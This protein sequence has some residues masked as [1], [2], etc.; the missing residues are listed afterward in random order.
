MRSAHESPGSI[1]DLLERLAN[2]WVTLAVIPDGAARH[3][4]L[5]GRR[6]H[7]ASALAQNLDHPLDGEFFGLA[8]IT[9]L[10]APPTLDVAGGDPSAS[11]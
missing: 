1:I 7:N 5:L 3:S 2:L 10:A 6:Q 8:A 11:C 4:Q 9:W